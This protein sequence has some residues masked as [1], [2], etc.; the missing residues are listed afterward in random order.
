MSNFLRKIKR[1]KK[2]LNGEYKE[3]HKEE[4]KKRKNEK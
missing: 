1:N 4:R 2:K 3:K